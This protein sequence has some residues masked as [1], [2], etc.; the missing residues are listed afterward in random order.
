MY[1]SFSAG[2][3]SRPPVVVGFGTL[4]GRPAGRASSWDGAEVDVVVVEGCDG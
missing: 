1:E 4:A 3:S 2:S